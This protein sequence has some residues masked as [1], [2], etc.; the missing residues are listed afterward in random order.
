MNEMFLFPSCCPLPADR[1]LLVRPAA[2]QGVVAHRLTS[3]PAAACTPR[4]EAELLS[5]RAAMAA[6]KRPPARPALNQGRWETGCRRAALARDAT[7]PRRAWQGHRAPRLAGPGPTCAP[8]AAPRGRRAARLASSTEGP[9]PGRRQLDARPGTPR[10]AAAAAAAADA[11]S[12]PS[13]SPAAL[14]AP[15]RAGEREPDTAPHA[16]CTRARRDAGAPRS[17]RGARPHAPPLPS[18]PSPPHTPPPHPHDTPY[19]HTLQP[20]ASLARTG[21]HCSPPSSSSA[22]PPPPRVH[23]LPPAWASGG[24]AS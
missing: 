17:P 2:G 11:T 21:S 16:P 19:T 5:C 6:E 13:P 3:H 4:S 14:P 15:P 23:P 12:S 20:R 24:S 22:P 9:R 8:R 7:R 18:S 1:G 10:A